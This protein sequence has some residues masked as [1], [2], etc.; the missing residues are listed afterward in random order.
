[1][2]LSVSVSWKGPGVGE[3]RVRYV[4]YWA[5]VGWVLGYSG[6]GTGLQRVGYWAT[7]GWV[8]GYR[9]W[10]LGWLELMCDCTRLGCMGL[11]NYYS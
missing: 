9:G 10:V 6:L 7:V 4:G 8:L 11:T 2:E 5:I 3:G 1:M